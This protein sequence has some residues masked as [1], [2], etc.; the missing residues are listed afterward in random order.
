MGLSDWTTVPSTNLDAVSY[1]DETNTLGVT[2][3][4]GDVWHY[5]GVPAWMHDG[6]IDAGS[7]GRYFRQW[8]RGK[9]DGAKV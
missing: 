9:F 1:D 8:I 6:L 2:F 3:L 7:P 5:A 4:N